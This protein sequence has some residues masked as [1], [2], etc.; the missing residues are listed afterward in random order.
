[1]EQKHKTNYLLFH[2]I[3]KENNDVQ[4]NE[5]ISLDFFLKVLDSIQYYKKNK[6]ISK[7]NI[8]L[9]FDDGNISDYIFA[10]KELKKRNLFS[11]FFIVPNLV[12]SKN[13]LNWN[14]VRDLK[15]NNMIIGSHSLSHQSLTSLDIHSV[16][17]EMEKSKDIIE[18]KLMEKI[19]SFSFPFGNF[20]TNLIKIAKKVGYKK[21]FTSKH[22]ISLNDDLYFKRNSFNKLLKFDDIIKIFEANKYMRLKWLVEDN[23]KYPLKN[24]LNEKT[25]LRLR[26]ILLN[27]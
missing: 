5:D 14:M 24:I 7:N 23:L 16:K 25:Y 3:V 22:G 10:L 1:M 15:K 11:Y 26:K 4:Y 12:D 27:R 19:D 8:I 21:I 6:K 13:F 9:T 2:R 17:Y 20:N 18:N